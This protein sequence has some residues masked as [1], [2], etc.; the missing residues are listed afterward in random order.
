MGS[1]SKPLK[2]KVDVWYLKLKEKNV[3]RRRSCM[4]RRFF[5]IYPRSTLLGK[6]VESTAKCNWFDKEINDNEG[7]C[8]CQKSD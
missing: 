3:T 7:A 6:A 2:N 8:A 1:W 4:S 5:T